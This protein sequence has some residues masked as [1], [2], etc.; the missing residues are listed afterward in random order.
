MIDGA[1]VFGVRLL[2]ESV[3]L[4]FVGCDETRIVFKSLRQQPFFNS[5]AFQFFKLSELLIIC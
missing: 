1:F 5:Q 3:G 4:P 2:F